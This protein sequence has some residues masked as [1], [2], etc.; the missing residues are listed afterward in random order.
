MCWLFLLLF[1]LGWAAAAVA[2]FLGSVGCRH[3]DVC[4]GACVALSV[5][6]CVCVLDL[7]VVVGLVRGY[8][9]SCANVG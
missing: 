2:R 7:V 1:M 9:V 8:G 4:G 6:V 5:C 3:A